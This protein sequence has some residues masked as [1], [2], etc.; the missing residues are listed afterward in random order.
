MPSALKTVLP[1]PPIP[2]PLF[3]ADANQKHQTDLKLRPFRASRQP[4][5]PL[6]AHA[7]GRRAPNLE[8][9][10][11]GVGRDPHENVPARR[12][13]TL[14]RRQTIKYRK[15]CIRRVELMISSFVVWTFE[16]IVMTV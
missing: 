6:C 14:S 16:K 13:A 3:C 11:N 2:L 8:R 4:P 10:P 12:R 1:F 7:H 9:T 5:S 15:Q